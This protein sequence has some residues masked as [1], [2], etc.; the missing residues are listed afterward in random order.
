MRHYFR[1]EADEIAGRFGVEEA[2]VLRVLVACQGFDPAGLFARDLAECLR[3]QIARRDRFDSAMAALIDNL[4]LLG[5][6]DFHSLKRICGIDED[7]LLAMLA[8][9]RALDLRLGGGF[10][11]SAADIIVPD[12]EVREAA[13]GSWAVE[14]NPETLPCV[15]VDHVYFAHVT[16]LTKDPADRNFL[17]ECLQNAN[18]LTRGLAQR[19]KT[20]LKVASEIVRQQDAFLVHAARHLRPLNLRTVAAAIGMHESTVSRATAN[21]YMLTT[22]GVFEL[23]YFFTALIAL[24]DG[25]TRIRRKPCVTASAR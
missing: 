7:D 18:W 19:T 4:D 16:G 3:V 13:D 5:K 1:G 6:R 11:G 24:A 22:R 21:K 14:L 15:L 23:H 9:I 8:E 12:V 10:G 17:S 25:A 2:F 20:I